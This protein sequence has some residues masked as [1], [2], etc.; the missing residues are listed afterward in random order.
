MIHVLYAEDEANIAELVHSFLQINAPEC[1]LEVVP[2][3]STCLKRMAAGGVDV[4]MVDMMLPNING[5]QIIGEL[6]ARGDPTPII[7]VS[8]HGHNE[9]AVQALRAGA[10]DCIDKT[11]TQFLQIGE[12][13]RH[14]HA[15]HLRR[16]QVA[17]LIPSRTIPW[18]LLC[19]E[20]DP[21]LGTVWRNFLAQN[22]PNLDL[23]TT[24]THEE[25]TQLLHGPRQVDAVLIGPDPGGV[26]ALD[27]LR[28][29]RSR[30]DMIPTVVVTPHGDS[31]TAIAAIKLGAHDYLKLTPGYLP[32]LVMSL[33]AALRQSEL[34]TLNGQL[35]EQLETLNQS[36]ETKVEHRTRELVSEI[37]VRK[38]AETRLAY[39]SM[40]LLRVQE[41]ERR[42][43][44]RE[45]H[46]QFGQTLTGLKL[47]L[48]M[49][50]RHTKDAQAEPL[51]AEALTAVQTLLTDVRALTQ[52]LRPRVLDDLGLQPAVEWIAN[53]F[54]QQSGLDITVDVSLPPGRLPGELETVVFRLV[55]EALT[56]VTRHS[57]STTASVT[58]AAD[59]EQLQVEISDRGR[60]FD[61]DAAL[62]RHTS[63]GLSGME[64]RVQLAGGRLEIVSPP[65]RG[66]RLHA[67]FNLNTPPPQL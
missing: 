57:G 60:G 17:R 64:E 36:L 42:T 7:M 61:V 25:F 26:S 19:L 2:D 62:A 15:R 14:T 10:V 4:L 29:V 1:Q 45:L 24:A 12:I 37:E 18:H 46:D 48:E 67:A 41:N 28:E 47:Q 40:R 6:V 22:A 56:N 31:D 34:A 53:Q 33:N 8:S 52:Q 55:Q 51:V 59:A 3:G 66:T 16:K 11:T 20:A 44:A 27:I 50:R 49:I 32:E 54:R 5:L 9:L 30:P 21:G 35:I 63:V 65:G 58:V 39:L 13:V 38:S 23:T 43:I